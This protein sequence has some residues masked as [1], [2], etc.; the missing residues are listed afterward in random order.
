MRYLGCERYKNVDFA[1]LL[2]S[3]QSLLLN[4]YQHWKN[5]A[6]NFIISIL[7]FFYFFPILKMWFESRFL[8][9]CSTSENINGDLICLYHHHH[10]LLLL[11]EHR[12]SMKS[13]QAL[14]SPAIPLTLFH[15]LPIFLTSSSVVLCHILF[16]LP[17][18]LYP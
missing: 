10:F 7:V 8:C 15:D 16:G 3:S 9:T 14:R 17:V 5:Q 4:V 1:V 18:S 13:F 6:I 2:S 12:S 11:V